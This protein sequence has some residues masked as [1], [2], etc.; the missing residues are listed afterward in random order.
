[1][2][3]ARTALL[4]ALRGGPSYGRDLIRRIDRATA[5]RVRLADGSVYP[6]LKALQGQRLVR[7]WT[8]VPGRT[9][10]GRARTYYELTVTGVRGA[11]ASGEALVRLAGSSANPPASPADVARTVQR[12]RRGM[13]LSEFAQLLADRM[14]RTRKKTTG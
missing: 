12:V 13:E 8:V 7:S 11:R 2:V 10:G 9:R 6:A 14:R 3:T 1:M 4:Q 5:G